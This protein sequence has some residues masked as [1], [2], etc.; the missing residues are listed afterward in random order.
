MLV[1]VNMIVKKTV[2]LFNLG[3]PASQPVFQYYFAF[4][5][6]TIFRPI[7][8]SICWF[9]S[10]AV[11]WSYSSARYLVISIA[12][13]VCPSIDNPINDNPDVWCLVAAHLASSVI[14]A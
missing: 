5:A 12:L 13:R 6:V 14:A 4:I 11:E 10:P 7:Y 2:V 9:V 1:I 3:V 8:R